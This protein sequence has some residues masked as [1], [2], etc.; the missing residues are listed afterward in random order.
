M[1]GM[2]TPGAPSPRLKQRSRL[3]AGCGE[4]RSVRR[5]IPGGLAHFVFASRQN[6]R[7]IPAKAGIQDR[8]ATFAGSAVNRAVRCDN[9]VR[10]EA[11]ALDPGFRR[12]DAVSS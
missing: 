7:V 9:A 1:P 5:L 6:Y 11:A 4:I 2:A 8:A 10:G 12:G 3:E